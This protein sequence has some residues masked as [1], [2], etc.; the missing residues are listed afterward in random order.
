MNY[1]LTIFIPMQETYGHT[2]GQAMNMLTAEAAC[3]TVSNRLINP[4][5][6]GMHRLCMNG[7]TDDVL[8]MTLVGVSIQ[9]TNG[10]YDNRTS[11]FELS[12]SRVDLSSCI[13]ACL[14]GSFL[15]HNYVVVRGRHS[16]FCCDF[17]ARCDCRLTF[18]L[19]VLESL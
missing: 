16:R 14:V 8:I 12:G 7:L 15:F 2:I 11:L 18:T 17:E 6:F 9:P 4:V 5:Y 1:S 10:C 3:V 13:T 19:R